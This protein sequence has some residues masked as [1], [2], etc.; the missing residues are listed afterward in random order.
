MFIATLIAYTHQFYRLT[1][2]ITFIQANFKKTT[3]VEIMTLN[4][5]FKK[6]TKKSKISYRK[7]KLQL[8]KY[9]KR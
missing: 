2:K 6:C 3:F 7:S 4:C 1:R 5:N 9:V 8:M